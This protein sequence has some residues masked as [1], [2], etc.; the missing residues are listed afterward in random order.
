MRERKR[1]GGGGRETEGR[2]GLVTPHLKYFCFGLVKLIFHQSVS[3]VVFGASQSTAHAGLSLSTKPHSCLSTSPTSPASLTADITEPLPCTQLLPEM[4]VRC[5]ENP[6]G[7]AATLSPRSPCSKSLQSPFIS[8]S[9][10]LTL[11]RGKSPSSCPR[12]RMQE[13]PCCDWLISN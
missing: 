7:S 6:S 8:S 10:V 2:G 3:L 1:M 13:L 5:G 4:V 11:N 9:L 12:A